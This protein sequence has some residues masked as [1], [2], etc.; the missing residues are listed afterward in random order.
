[1]CEAPSRLTLCELIRMEL[2]GKDRAQSGYDSILWKIRAGYA[3]VLYGSLSLIV[4]LVEKW[5]VF[6]PP[7]KG[8]IIFAL[9]IVGF[10]LFAAI[11]DSFFLRSKLRVI[12]A[13]DKLVDLSVDLVSQQ[14]IS[15]EKRTE[16]NNM[17]HVSGEQRTKIVDKVQRPL[18]PVFVLYGGTT[19]L[20]LI[21]I[22]LMFVLPGHSVT[23]EGPLP[24]A[25]KVFK[26][27]QY[28]FSFYFE[29][30]SLIVNENYLK[31]ND[32]LKKLVDFIA[33]GLNAENDYSV[34]ITGKASKEFVLENN[35][36]IKSNYE[37]SRA[38]TE[39]VQ[40][41]IVDKMSVLCSEKINIDFYLC[42]LSN[43]QSNIEKIEESRIV[44]V[45]IHE[46]S[47]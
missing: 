43:Q 1:M 30:G 18:L 20:A 34:I 39:T 5:K 42:G 11:L 4:T 46:K 19:L 38:R 17:L 22:V 13:K 8:I 44:N 47:S 12:I 33:S 36:S 35:N 10:S 6:L 15:A 25:E 3:A 7:T 14:H 26:T 2:E 45:I 9:L 23:K 32:E 37:L 40:K 21:I 16:I 31:N 24:I 41:I 28:D 29:K 27:S